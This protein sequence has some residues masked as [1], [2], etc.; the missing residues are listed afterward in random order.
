MA[1]SV[2]NEIDPNLSLQ[3]THFGSH[4]TEYV[5][6]WWEI[7]RGILPSLRYIIRRDNDFDTNRS[8]K[9]RLS[10]LPDTHLNETQ[11]GIDPYG[12]D[13]FCNICSH[14]L[15]NTYFHCQGCESLLAKDFNICIGCYND[16]SYAIN[17]EMLK[18]GKKDMAC[19]FHHVGMPKSQCSNPSKHSINMKCTE[20]NKCLLCH[21]ICHTVF[22]KRRRF[23]TEDRQR[24]MLE[25]CE[26]L[27]K[28][29]DIKYSLETAFQLSGDP[30]IPR[31]DTRSNKP[32]ST[33]TADVRTSHTEGLRIV[34]DFRQ[35]DMKNNILGMD[36]KCMELPVSPS[37][38][39]QLCYENEAQRADVLGPYESVN[40]AQGNDKLKTLKTPP[41]AVDVIDVDID[42]EVSMDSDSS[43]D[44]GE[45]NWNAGELQ[46][47]N[48]TGTPNVEE[49]HP[50][51]SES[52][53]NRTSILSSP[54][55]T[56]YN[57]VTYCSMSP[58]V[59]PNDSN[60]CIYY[61][62]V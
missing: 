33:E 48:S 18:C 58:S 25:R 45:S 3:A 14:E 52:V 38:R 30:M 19:H 37:A 51:P 17:V 11:N 57:D 24:K 2:P 22:Q 26:Q 1:D 15:S 49:V 46:N 47:V 32:T 5:L 13:Y 62:A 4:R 60:D 23:Y 44:T 39:T 34:T 42:N 21:C 28:D 12:N 53:A 29:C 59:V 10:E 27:I 35:R 9:I 41:H 40:G 31:Q 55:A 50:V 43:R 56:V 16:G 36:V 20:C 61:D 6:S 54:K 7:V 8:N